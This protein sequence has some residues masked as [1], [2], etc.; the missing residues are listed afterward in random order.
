[1]VNDLNKLE[2][3]IVSVLM[4]AF[5]REDFI[6]EAIESVLVSSFT[7]FELIICDDCSK[8]DTVAIAN[9]YAAIDKRVKV[10]VNDK[11]LGDYPNRNKAAS[12][13]KGKYLKYLDSDDKLYD[14]GLAYAVTQ[15]EKYPDSPL[16]MYCS[17]EM[18]NVDSEVWSSEKIIRE[19][20]FVKQYLS[21]GPT[22][23]IINRKFFVE[24]GGF[25]TRFGPASDMFFNIRFASKYPIV[26][27]PSLFFYYRI[28]EGQEKNNRLGYLKFGYLYFKELM[29]KVQLPLK[30]KE[31]NFLY[32]KM[33]KRHSINLTKFYWQTKDLKAV[34]EV[35]VETKFS[36]LAYLF[37]FFK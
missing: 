12:L 20:F 2:T 26:L 15:M 14:F 34:R 19:H 24:S 30:R 7:D 3:P 9:K 37:S 35:M 17:S 31:I 36:F 28:H 23:T 10:F 16:G 4:T 5:N 32:K 13:A 25:D 29:Q 11:N 22:G 27:L 18:G 1:M 21:M 33:Q 6:A 8:D